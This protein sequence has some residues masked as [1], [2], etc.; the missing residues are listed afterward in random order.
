M[1]G[2]RHTYL[3]ELAESIWQWCERKE[4]WLRAS[5]IQSKE[6]NIADE[7]SRRMSVETEW[8]LSNKVFKIIFEKLGPF[9]IDL[10]A[11][12]NNNKCKNYVSWKPD[13]FSVAIDAFTISW[14]NKN[15]YAF[16]PFSLILKT[17]QKII[18]D[19][20]VGVIVVPLWES[21]AWFPLFQS[22]TCSEILTFGPANDLLTSPFSTVHPLAGSLILAAAKLSGKLLK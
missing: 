8:A 13:P 16:P 15:F 18:D 14:T 19:R 12:Q 6:N 22:L 4:I 3:Y 20:A 11:S 21:Q 9:D 5:Y 2:I 10:F 17:L 1:G 7:E